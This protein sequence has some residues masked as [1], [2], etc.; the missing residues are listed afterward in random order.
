[1]HFVGCEVELIRELLKMVLVTVH[2]IGIDRGR[3]IVGPNCDNGGVAVVRKLQH[4]G[5]F[6]NNCTPKRCLHISVHFQTNGLEN[7]L[8]T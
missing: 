3:V 6:C 8:F 2:G 5:G 1:V 7:T 4:N